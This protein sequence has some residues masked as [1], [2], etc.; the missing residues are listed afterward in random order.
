MNSAPFCVLGRAVGNLALTFVSTVVRATQRSDQQVVAKYVSPLLQMLLILYV[1]T[2]NRIYLLIR[3][4]RQEVR[5][6]QDILF[7]SPVRHYNL[8]PG[9]LQEAQTIVELAT[10]PSVSIQCQ[11]ILAQTYTKAL[12]Q[13]P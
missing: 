4:L 13:R 5:E 9:E 6:V 2:L 1:L 8:T 3:S 10:K 12:L 7:P 11:T